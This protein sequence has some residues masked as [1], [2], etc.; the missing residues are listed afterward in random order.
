[1]NLKYVKFAIIIC[2]IFE[3]FELI[4]TLVLCLYMLLSFVY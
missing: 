4:I 3:I 1:M 2:V